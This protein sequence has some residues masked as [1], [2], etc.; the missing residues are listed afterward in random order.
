VLFR[1]ISDELI[2][3]VSR[4]GGLALLHRFQSNDDF[5][6]SISCIKKAENWGAA[7]STGNHGV[8]RAKL[9]LNNGARIVC[10]DVANGYTEAVRSFTSTIKNLIIK[11]NYKTA[12]MVGNV[13]TAEGFDALADEGADIVRVGIGS[14]QLCTTTKVT[15]VGMPQLSAIGK[16]MDSVSYNRNEFPVYM[17]ADGG[18]RYS[19]DIV[20]AIVY[21]ADFVMIGSLFGSTFES[22][23]K[24]VIRGMASRTL[25]EEYYHTVKSIEGIEKAQPKTI[26]VEDLMEQ[27][28][29]G[30]KSAMTYL[31]ARV[32][33]DLSE[34]RY[35]DVRE[36]K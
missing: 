13:V 15:G 2:L 1:S 16:C 9:A 22:A 31:N 17:A 10:I 32:L 23:H 7:I 29:W 8:E 12:L 26:S 33:D 36:E 20:K 34:V 21:G 18:I 27:L 3:E 25:Q 19:G 11:G 5:D 6:A 24:G 30:I 28:S 4:C 14:G 35:V